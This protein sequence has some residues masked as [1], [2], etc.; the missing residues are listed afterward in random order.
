MV[1]FPATSLSKSANI[2]L[3][4]Y[5]G[6][7]IWH[8]DHRFGGYEVDVLDDSQHNNP[9]KLIM[10]RYWVHESHMPNFMRDGRKTLLG[11]RDITNTTNFRTSIISILPV[12]P[13][14]NNLP[15]LILDPRFSREVTWLASCNS[16]LAFD[17]VARQKLGG[18]HM[19]FFLLKQ[20]PVLPPSQ[21]TAIC[22]WD[23]NV[24]LGDWIFP[25][26]FELTYTA[27][28]LEPFAKDC[29]YDGPPF[30]W[31]E[32]RRFLLRCELDAAYFHLYG[33]ER[34][35]VDYIM[36]TFP[37]V[38]RKDEKQSGEYRTKRVI[39]EIYDKMKQAIETG[40]PYRTRLEPPPT[41]PSMA[42]PPRMGMKV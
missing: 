39:L 23:N 9:L 11:F 38:K 29:G 34:D 32:E 24:S 16:S 8:F 20:L 7:M 37:I 21:Y 5:E 19:N 6:K 18:T 15:N 1:F 22:T 12:V 35:N 2:E 10:P 36:E 26:A 14:G 30:H 13:C 27:W 28:D 40:E 41:D 31:N 17:Y 42:H 3:P 33:I 25:R 4:L